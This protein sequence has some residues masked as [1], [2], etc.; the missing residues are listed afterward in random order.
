MCDGRE[1]TGPRFWM[2]LEAS[3][4]VSPAAHPLFPAHPTRTRPQVIAYCCRRKQSLHRCIVPQFL[5]GACDRSGWDGVLISRVATVHS[6]FEFNRGFVIV[7]KATVGKAPTWLP[8]RLGHCV[9][10]CVGTRGARL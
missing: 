6:P 1:R 5:D 10:L 2:G 8:L 3:H 4:N 9:G 7:L